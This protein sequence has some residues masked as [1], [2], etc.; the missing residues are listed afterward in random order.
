MNCPHCSG[1][2]QAGQRFCG[3]CGQGLATAGSH[4]GQCGNELGPGQRFCGNCGASAAGSG[5]LQAAPPPPQ[6]ADVTGDR[7]IVTV[8]FT[9]VS[10]FTAMSEKLDPEAVTEIINNFFKVLVEPIYRYGGVVDKYIGDAIMAL[11]GAPVA[12]EDDA[13]RAVRAAWEMQQKAQQH[14]EVLE[15]QTGILLKVR[16]GLNTG[17]VVAGQVGA[18]QRSDYTVMGDTVNLAQRMESNARVG[19]VLVTAETYQQTRHAFRFEALPPIKVKGK[20]DAVEVFEVAGP[21]P[22]TR[23][24][25]A[26]EEMFVGRQLELQ[27]LD[28]YWAATLKGRPHLVVLAGEAGVGKS[29]V[30]WRQL[31]RLLSDEADVRFARCLSYE[32]QTAYAMVS[33]LLRSWIGISDQDPASRTRSALENFVGTFAPD[34]ERALA[35]LGHLLALEVDNPAVASLSPRQAR[36]GAFITLDDIVVAQARKGPVVLFLEDLHWADEASLEWL[37]GLLERV[38]TE[39]GYLPL[40]VL[41]QTRSELPTLRAAADRLPGTQ[42]SIGPLQPADVEAM[43]TLHLGT[44]MENL[45]SQAQS[46]VT[47]ALDR[48]EGNPFYLA[49]VLRALT[50]GGILV[51]SGATWTIGKSAEGILPTSVRGAVSARLDRLSAASRQL[52]Q[53]AAVIGKRFTRELLVTVLGRPF[54]PLDEILAQKLLF[55]RGEEIGFTQTLI[56]EVAYETLLIAHRKELHR[57]V[58]TAL[59][60]YAGPDIGPNAATIAE[61]F[62]RAEDAPRAAHYL[63]LAGEHA[64]ASSAISEAMD[65][66]RRALEWHATA[67]DVGGIKKNAGQDSAQAVESAAPVTFPKAEVMLQMALLET[68]RGELE[69]A[70]AH[71]DDHDALAGRS[72]RSVRARGDV[73]E[74]A[75]DFT[76]SLA[77]YREA[78]GLAAGQSLEQARVWASEGNIL[79]RMGDYEAAIALC[80]KSY[81]ELEAAQQPAEAAFVHGVLGISYHRMNDFE[82]ALREHAAALRLREKAGDID[83]VA[84][85]HNNLGMLAVSIGRWTEAYQHY[86]RALAM[87]R[88][89]GDR[90]HLAM[91]LNNLG[92]LLLK[93][94]DDAMAERHFQEAYKLAVQM[95]DRM[96]ALTAL[97]NLG[98]SLLSKGMPGEALAQLDACLVQAAEAGHNEFGPELQLGRARAFIALQDLEASSGALDLAISESAGNTQFMALVDQVRSEMALSSGDRE[99]ALELAKRSLSVLGDSGMQLELGRT[100][101]LLVQAAPMDQAEGHAREALELLSRLGARKELQA[102]RQAWQ[103][104]ASGVSAASASPST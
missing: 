102:T 82:S 28:A 72:V 47:N 4:C 89:L 95:G 55:V 10:G 76:G 6:P 15:K 66:Y 79:R 70:I 56:W 74:R 24:I 18:S 59:E 8:L 86:S 84:K 103:E 33:D 73:L 67:Q 31:K 48:A 78:G 20:T 7:R 38:S 93:Q 100:L 19:K 98:F 60:A 40:L 35:L 32:L 36:T 69:T 85:T 27:A 63:Y 51:R 29:A 21:L 42:L 97:G 14:A 83:G 94:G 45:P 17:L 50:E 46:I 25:G 34:D 88:K 22:R 54:D 16:I 71:L 104:R 12:H 37:C 2:V 62:V 3:Q 99:A 57:K 64:R 39:N 41:C 81:V 1:P 87:F 90:P 68:L 92:D 53:T 91:M 23:V 75:G 13:E 65:F 80:R 77:T 52:L 26:E 43:A 30:A 61:H 49:E 101:L 5:P 96:N 44:T 9:D 58:G 11:F